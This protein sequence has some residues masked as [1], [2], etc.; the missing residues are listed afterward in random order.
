MM[1]VIRFTIGSKNYALLTK[2]SI[3]KKHMYIC[4]K[5]KKL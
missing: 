5:I 3:R 4:K 1:S 2:K